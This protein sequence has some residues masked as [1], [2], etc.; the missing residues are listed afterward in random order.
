MDFF[1]PFKQVQPN[2]DEMTATT[3]FVCPEKQFS[4]SRLLS[5]SSVSTLSLLPKVSEEPFPHFLLPGAYRDR[6]T[7][8]VN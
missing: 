7:Y 4:W 5:F 2:S 6:V 3:N 1:V 8:D